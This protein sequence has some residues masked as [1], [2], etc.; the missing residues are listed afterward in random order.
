MT[1]PSSLRLAGAALAAAVLAGCTTTPPRLTLPKGEPLAISVQAPP[2]GKGPIPIS[3]QAM[4][5]NV[6]T[7]KD[8]T[9]FALIDGVVKYERTKNDRKKVSV[10]PGISSDQSAPASA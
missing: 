5:N 4:G 9:L 7:G 2:P 3:N 1:T 10:Y 6:G 8:Y